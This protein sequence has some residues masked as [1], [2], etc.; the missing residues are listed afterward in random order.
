MQIQEYAPISHDT[1]TSQ[2][3]NDPDNIGKFNCESLSEAEVNTSNTPWGYI[4]LAAASS[5]FKI[6]QANAAKTFLAKHLGQ[7]E[8]FI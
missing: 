5:S 3:L 6:M 1:Q 8:G 7:L 4:P 2:P